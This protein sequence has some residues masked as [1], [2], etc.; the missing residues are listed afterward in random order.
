[1]RLINDLRMNKE[2][3]IDELLTACALLDPYKKV[4]SGRL[5]PND[6]WTNEG[7]EYLVENL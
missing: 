1:M 4:F 5:D 7:I 6:C 3:L 2:K